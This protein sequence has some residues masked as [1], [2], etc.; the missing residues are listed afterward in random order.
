MSLAAPRQ[1][2]KEQDFV[3]LIRAVYTAG[4][5]DEN[6]WIEWKSELDLE[7]RAT[8]A[9]I[10]QYILGFANRDP[11]DLND[12]CGGAGILIVGVEPRSLKG[13]HPLDPAKLRP[14]IEA[15]V[16]GASGPK[17]VHRYV[18]LDG[19][20]VL[21][22]TVDPPQ[23][24]DRIFTAR[25]SSDKVV[26]GRVYIRRHGRTE[27]A[28]AADM[29]M[30]QARLTRGAVGRGIEVRFAGGPAYVADVDGLLAATKAWVDDVVHWKVNQARIAEPEQPMEL[31]DT[32]SGDRR[33]LEDYIEE[34]EVWRSN[35]RV[36]A[37]ELVL[38]AATA[39]CHP[40]AIEV[41]DTEKKFH[42]GV[43]VVAFFAP[44]GVVPADDVGD[45]GEVPA[46]PR[47]FG[48]RT[49]FPIANLRSRLFPM[50]GLGP[51]SPS[52]FDLRENRLVFAVGDLRP[53]STR[54]SDELYVFTAADNDVVSVSWTATFRGHDRQ[55]SGTTEIPVDRVPINVDPGSLVYGLAGEPLDGEY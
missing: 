21:V 46:L 29:D 44:A 36:W 7:L 12:E 35:A 24:G 8:K 23:S 54:R 33:S 43:E 53:G 49:R 1:L 55:V 51:P 47:D 17:W 2:E 27:Q 14:H 22:V 20:K 34:M 50:A 41:V 28:E 6:D 38:T 10:A 31:R 18:E 42:P 4:A 39:G 52:S 9:N 40:G 45:P 5:E 11:E 37:D 26:S 19:V 13:V 32:G 15:I 30:L 25:K 16:G 48:R 3:A